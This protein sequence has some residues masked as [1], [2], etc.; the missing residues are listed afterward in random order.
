MNW[1]L[2]TIVFRIVCGDGNHA[3]QF[4]E[5]VRLVSAA[6]S[7]NALKKASALGLS[8][9][10]TFHNNKQ[11][12]LHWKFVNVAELICIS[13]WIDGAEVYSRIN[14]VSNADAY[15][16]LVQNKAQHLQLNESRQL[17]KII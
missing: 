13:E 8:E 10:Q 14:E 1:Y 7:A 12:L 16:N 17:L 4:D 2:A 11:Q 5:Q 3:A 15:I 6:S 9:Q